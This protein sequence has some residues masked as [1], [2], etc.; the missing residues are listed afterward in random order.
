MYL[1]SIATLERLSADNPQ[2]YGSDLAGSYNNLAVFYHDIQRFKESEEMCLSGIAILERLAANNPQAYGA[3]L[4]DSYNNLAVFY[5]NIQRFK[6]SEEMHLSA[7]AILERLVVD[8]PQA[9]ESDLANLYIELADFYDATHRFKE[10]EKL[11]H[12][13]IVIFERLAGDAPQLYQKQL[14]EIYHRLDSSKVSNNEYHEETILLERSLKLCEGIMKEE[15]NEFICNMY[16]ANL[17]ILVGR[18]NNDKDYEKAYTYNAEL[19]LMQ[20]A[21]YEDDNEECRINYNA[22]LINQSWHANLLG[23]F[24]EGEQFS[25]EALKVAPTEH[26]AYTNLAAALLFQGKVKEAEK[27][28]SEYKGEFKDEMLSDFAEFERLGI[29]PEE[30]KGDVDRIKAMLKE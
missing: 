19:L 2:V 11:Y 12:A 16:M 24:K 18:Y 7:I 20:Q 17:L 26:L 21:Y 5:H 9:Y 13:A 23:K 27:V 25:L 29:I 3:D 30:R 14:A 8:N 10:S 15:T 28:Y 4:A 1:A 6:K 22:S